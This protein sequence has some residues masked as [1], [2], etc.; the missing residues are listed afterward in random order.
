LLGAREKWKAEDMLKIDTD[1]Y[2]AFDDFLA[3]QVIA[4]YDARKPAPANLKDA[5]DTLRHWN[6]RMEKGQAAPMIVSLVYEQLRKLAAERAAIGSGNLYQS[7]A[8]PRAL[9]NLLRERPRDWFPDYDALLLRCLTGAIEAGRK[10]QGSKA[11]L[12][13][14]GQYRALRIA[15]P[16]AGRLPLIGRYFNIGP[17]PMSGAPT[18]VMQYTGVLGPSLR[19]IVDLGDLEHSFANLTTGESGQ[20]LSAHYRDQWDAF[21][22]GR[23]FPMRFSSLGAQDVLVVKPR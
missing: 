21:Y 3:K 18:T 22:A 12:W 19:M 20:R 16:I 10:I 23:S 9:E 2:S 14:Y 15:S 8:A 17:V 5:V 4:A 13:D 11:S 6:G 1:T 7:R